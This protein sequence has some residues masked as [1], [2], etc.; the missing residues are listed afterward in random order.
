MANPP[1]DRTDVRAAL[2]RHLR[3]AGSTPDSARITRRA[4]PNTPAPLSPAQRRLWFMER[5]FPGSAAYN[6]SAAFRICGPLDVPVLRSA[7]SE[8]VRR[9]EVLRTRFAT[10]AEGEPQ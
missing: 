10:T 6:V 7:V 4:D 3:V 9:H 2:S 1:T 5:L 8:L